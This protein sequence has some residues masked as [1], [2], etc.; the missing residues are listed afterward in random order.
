M[1]RRFFSAFSAPVFVF[2][3]PL[4]FVDLV[5]LF[6]YALLST[7]G[8]GGGGGVEK[9]KQGNE[10]RTTGEFRLLPGQAAPVAK[11]SIKIDSGEESRKNQKEKKRR[12]ER[13]GQSSL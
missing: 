1:A 5:L 9:I 10:E 12:V 7:F 3:F 4:S 13:R 2:F 6:H 11:K 8:G